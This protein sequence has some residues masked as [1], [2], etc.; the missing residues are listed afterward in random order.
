MKKK[1]PFAKRYL[2]YCHT[3]EIT[4]AVTATSIEV[5]G[6]AD[7][8]WHVSLVILIKF[9]SNCTVVILIKF[10]SNSTVVILRLQAAILQ[11]ATEYIT[12]MEKDKTKLQIQ[13]EHTK[14]MLSQLGQD[15]MI[16]DTYVSNSPPPSKRKKRDTGNYG[17]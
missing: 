4:V 11:H 14:R 5:L 10:S 12:S 7:G 17:S 16:T 15:R 1:P 8:S 2:S 9:S 6:R 13:L 3:L